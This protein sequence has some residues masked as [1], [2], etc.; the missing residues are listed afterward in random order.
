MLLRLERALRVTFIV[1]G[2]G[3]L[4]AIIGFALTSQTPGYT[5]LGGPCMQGVAMPGFDPW[6]GDR[7]GR[8]VETSDCLADPPS[9]VVHRFEEP[10]PTTCKTTP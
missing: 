1:V 9:T 6:T 3:V 4:T 10:I 8:I 5:Y 7:H 2:A